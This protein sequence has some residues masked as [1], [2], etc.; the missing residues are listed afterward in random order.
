VNKYSNPTVPPLRGCVNDVASLKALLTG[1]LDFAA[2]NIHSLTDGKA[3]KAKVLQEMDW[4]F[5]DAEPDDR[6]LLHFSGHGSYVASSDG[7]GDDGKSEIFCLVNMDW[8]DPDSYLV[9][10]DLR[11]WT[12][13]LPEGVRLVV[14]LDSCHSGTGTRFIMPPPSATGV[15]APHY[16][17]AVKATAARATMTENRAAMATPGDLE[18][19][20]TGEHPDVVRVRFLPPPAK[21][22]AAVDAARARRGRAAPKP[23]IDPRMNH[24]LLAACRVDQTSADA[25]IGGDYHG[26]FTYY[27]ARSLT[28]AGKEVDR[29]TLI[30]RVAEDLRAGHFDQVPQLEGPS[31]H[32]ALFTTSPD[33]SQPAGSVTNG[34]ATG[35]P[36]NDGGDVSRQ[37]LAAVKQLTLVVEELSHSR[38]AIPARAR[39]LR[40]V[41]S[42]YLVYVHGICRHD[43][44]YSNPWWDAL[45]PYVP[46]L[47]PGDLGDT[48]QEVLWSDLIGGTRALARPDPEAAELARRL[49][50]TL[51]DRADRYV[52]RATPP[53]TTSDEATRALA[54]PRGA[55]NIP[56][57]NC[58]NDFVVY[59]TN[60]GT[61]ARVIGR[62][63][64][65]VEPLLN[66]GARVEVIS[67]SW[68]TVV[69][70]EGL[71]QLDGSGASGRVHNWFT[72][73]AAL[74]IREVQRRLL[75]EAQDGA[76]PSLVDRWTNLDAYGDVVGGSLRPLGYQVDDEF[77]NLDAVGCT[78]VLGLVN[79]SCAH[80]SYFQ[81]E[82][83]A[84]NR[85]IFGERIEG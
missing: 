17:I 74:S 6:V 57:V 37:L 40:E 19:V 61:R 80:G 7:D 75:P 5:Q 73:G 49:L 10:G 72:V 58:I 50:D 62:F 21:I 32:G 44:G 85:D 9:N 28:A 2:R 25:Y 15:P 69:A 64:Q 56:G 41:G 20:L 12:Q 13:R 78:R 31:A 39:A 81:A 67:H 35:P 42:H 60:G 43:P 84:V 77:L 54:V 16:L 33:V 47:Q 83:L 27:L 76:R 34:P 59:L 82:N 45:S 3:T 23:P 18:A 71:R 52:L 14:V 29:G 53:A 46:S 79:P 38:R 30:D 11:R 65:V 8:D 1:T 4:L 55:I 63:L 66:G 24:V 51:A 48:R 22:Q 36:V 70:Y 26:A 68:G